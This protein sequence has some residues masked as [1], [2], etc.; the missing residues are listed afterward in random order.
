[1]YSYEYFA[2]RYLAHWYEKPMSKLYHGKYFEILRAVECHKIDVPAVVAGPRGWGK[3]TSGG[4]LL[5]LHCILYPNYEL[6]DTGAFSILRKH[7]FL[8]FSITLRNAQRNMGNV[9][10]ELEDNEDIIKT[11][12][13]LYRDPDRVGLSGTRKP[14]SKTVVETQNG[15][16][17]EA[18][19][20]DSKPR[21]TLWKAHRIELLISDDMEDNERARS[22]VRPVEDLKWVLTEV[23]P[24]VDF[25]KYGNML[26]L[27]TVINP[28][29]FT[30]RMI[31]HGESANWLTKIFRVY[32]EDKE[33]KERTYLWPECY[34]PAFIDKES[35]NIGAAA[36]AQEYQ[37][38]PTAGTMELTKKQC[39][40]YEFVD[41][42]ERL[43][44][45]RVFIGVDP[46]GSTTKRSD[47][48]AIVPIAYDHKSR[49]TYVLPAFRG[50]IDTIQQPKQ[51]VDAFLQWQEYV[52]MIGIES[53]AY[54]GALKESIDE[55]AVTAGLRIPTKKLPPPYGVQ[56]HDRIAWRTYSP[57]ANGQIL[58]LN[59][60]EHEI[61]IN[62]LIYLLTS[63]FD[64]MADALEMA[65]RLK[66][67]A[68]G[69]DLKTRGSM[70]ANVV[71][72]MT[73]QERQEYRRKRRTQR[74]ARSSVGVSRVR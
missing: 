53:G 30:S 64:D 18:Y 25:A 73:P 35:K 55:L 60:P 5:P 38:D 71:K 7:Y 72:K 43:H 46:A 44:Q 67:Q 56:K 40:T 37:Q 51:V 36:V 28:H 19:G 16:R 9:C 59:S 26:G 1:M 8:F 4:V 34:G 70:R 27:G 48:T 63:D 42:A 23:M 62:E 2:K 66:D 52:Q 74:M 22:S 3:T 31:K 50:K 45:M 57:I 54:Q 47:Y 10:A 68:I 15:V 11:F 61:M 33:T 41:I 17:M 6:N 29:S 65:I 49:I 21:G 58:F 12:G 24:A 69:A 20:R 39:G 13:G 32:E 14:R